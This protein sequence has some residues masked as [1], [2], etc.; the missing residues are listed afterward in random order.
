[1]ER[2]VGNRAFVVYLFAMLAVVPAVADP[3]ILFVSNLLF[4][5]MILAVGLNL[6]VGFAGQFALA[7]AAMFGIGAYAT[8]LLQVKGQLSF[9]LALPGGAFLAMAI[10]TIIALPA[11]RLS[12]LY[13]AL[14][15]LAFAQFTQWVFIHW[16]VVTFGAGG[17]SVPAVDFSA[18]SMRS[19]IGV[20]YL[21]WLLTIALIV[22]AWSAMQSRIGRAFIAIRDGEIAAQALGISLFKYKTMAFALSGFYAGVAGGLYAALLNYVAPDGYDLFQVVMHKAMVVVGG[23]GSIVGSILG[24][25]FLVIANEGLRQ[26]RSVQEIAFGAL[27]LVFVLFMPQGIVA[28][29]KRWLPGWEEPF[30]AIS[31]SRLWRGQELPA[32]RQQRERGAE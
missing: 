16:R 8:G 4:I 31:L 20:Y 6:L 19:E 5:Y 3:Y 11:L 18:L 9:W 2:F 26:F 25:L 22:F 13:L 32:D 23:I 30:H 27:L 12:G 7:N 15:T 24:A 21:S 17:F 10:G 29:I 28:M 1:M 14:A